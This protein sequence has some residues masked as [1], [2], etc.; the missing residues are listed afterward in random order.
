MSV[1]LECQGFAPCGALG[2]RMP[3]WLTLALLTS[4]V[5]DAPL[6]EL[7]DPT[8]EESHAVL[9]LDSSGKSSCASEATLLFSCCI[10]TGCGHL[11]SDEAAR[12]SQNI[13]PA[14]IS[15]EMGF[16]VCSVTAGSRSLST[17]SPFPHLPA[18]LLWWMAPTE[19]SI[20]VFRNV[21]SSA[22]VYWGA[23]FIHRLRFCPFQPWGPWCCWPWF[24]SPCENWDCSE[25]SWDLRMDFMSQRCRNTSSSPNMILTHYWLGDVSTHLLLS[26]CLLAR[27]VN[28]FLES[29]R[30]NITV[31]S[32]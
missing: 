21:D 1:A 27:S 32:C 22:H 19:S 11:F 23:A 25:S 24:L 18:A 8:A 29:D 13:L 5:W 20:P 17:L 12:R 10:S 6:P 16:V 3:W 31:R 30:I 28:T 7:Q 4:S 26:K 9:L 15:Q 2:L 14:C